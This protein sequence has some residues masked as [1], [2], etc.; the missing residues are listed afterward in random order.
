M[1]PTPFLG[2]RNQFRNRVCRAVAAACLL[3]LLPTA[4][5]AATIYP[6]RRGSVESLFGKTDKSFAAAIV[7]AKDR[8][9]L[10]FTEEGSGEH[11]ESLSGSACYDEAGFT[12]FII[13]RGK[14]AGSV[15][16]CGGSI[17]LHIRDG[18]QN[19]ATDGVPISVRYDMR[20][21]PR[22]AP[23]MPYFASSGESSVT[24][25]EPTRFSS[26]CPSYG[27]MAVRQPPNPATRFY[28]LD[29]GWALSFTFRWVDYRERLPFREGQRPISWRLVASRTR[30]DGSV[31][32]WGTL[33]EPVLLNW[34]PAGAGILDDIPMDYFLS[35]SLGPIYRD[36]SEVARTFWTTHRAEKW[37]GYL[38]PGMPTFEPKNPDSDALFFERC[39]EPFLDGNDNIDK[40]LYFNF[41]E[42][43]PKPKVLTMTPA[44]REAIVAGLDRI[45]HFREK[46]DLLRRDYLLDRFL[47]RPVAQRIVPQAARPKRLK[48]LDRK[49]D[50]SAE[51]LSLDGLG[52]IE[53]VGDLDDIAF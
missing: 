5:C 29:D 1:Y 16:E 51:E 31:A 50:L 24:R 39:L 7:R 15:A 21:Y 44:E 4:L 25:S 47:E 8:Q 35:A 9:I 52:T 23:G 22:P 46:V 33:A 53:P 37:I 42:G 40:A 11:Q 2:K 19:T 48:P 30:P 14:R 41:R 45:V 3:L 20:E 36:Y 12:L 49:R 32:H 13:S 17:S 27:S 38:D 28:L 6:V 43:I 26:E 18:V 34:A 10:P